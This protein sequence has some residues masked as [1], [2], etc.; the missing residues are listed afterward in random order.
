MLTGGNWAETYDETAMSALFAVL[1][2]VTDKSFIIY[3]YGLICL[4]TMR[5]TACYD[6]CRNK[7][8]SKPAA[9]LTD[10]NVIAR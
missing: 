4:Y 1:R 6:T 8:R 10:T 9:I 3:Q 5:Q 2:L 7:I